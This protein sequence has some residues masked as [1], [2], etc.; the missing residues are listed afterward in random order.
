VG[1]EY[2]PTTDTETSLDWLPVKARAARK[3]GRA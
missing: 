2:K 1:L 3:R